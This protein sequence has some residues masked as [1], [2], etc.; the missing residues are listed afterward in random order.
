MKI[1]I[2]PDDASLLETNGW[3]EMNDWIAELRDDGGAGPAGDGGAGPAGD[4]GPQLETAMGAP[5]AN[6]LAASADIGAGVEST[7]R[8]PIGDQ[9]RMPIAWCEMGSCISHHAD[10]A[11]LGEADIR[12]RAI[13]SGW[14][15]DALGRLSCPECQSRPGFWASHPVA[16]WD[17]NT[18]I[19]RTL[20]LA[21]ATR[22][23]RT[24]S[25][26]SGR[27]PA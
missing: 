15:V 13:S 17:R 10:P 4:G 1:K 21:T 5:P 22:N 2:R 26:A 11:A 16:L 3:L 9:L 27:Q 23:G 20:L 25:N 19:A 24:A 12:T 14:R 7:E 6:G 8:A 18:A